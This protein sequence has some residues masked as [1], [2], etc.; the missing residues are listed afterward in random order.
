MAVHASN[1]RTTVTSGTGERP[2]EPYG[3][4]RDPTNRTG[5][6]PQSLIGIPGPSVPSSHRLAPLAV[7]SQG[8]DW[9]TPRMGNEK[10][11]GNWRFFGGQKRHF[12][13]FGAGASQHK[14]LI[15]PLLCRPAFLRPRARKMSGASFGRG[16]YGVMLVSRTQSTSSRPGSAANGHASS[17][18]VQPARN[19]SEGALR[20]EG[21]RSLRSAPFAGKPLPS[22]M[23]TI[24]P[25]KPG[26]P[27]N[28][29]HQE[30]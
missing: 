15:W 28:R 13:V 23:R 18:P 1:I 30:N 19:R 8:P 3:Q 10:N 6:R 27:Q 20:F 16:L 2:R 17:P 26:N 25:I 4:R 9:P 5:H 21:S 12:S 24:K 11:G 22:N 14:P 29:D 7:L